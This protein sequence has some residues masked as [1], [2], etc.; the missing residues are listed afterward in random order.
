MFTSTKLIALF[1]LLGSAI[2]IPAAAPETHSISKRAINPV[3]LHVG[4][5]MKVES[6][7]KSNTV[8]G[9]GGL[10]VGYWTFAFDGAEYKKENFVYTLY[11]NES[12]WN[13]SITPPPQPINKAFNVSSPLLSDPCP[14]RKSDS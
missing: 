13:S 14:T 3:D 1:A 7:A 5:Y 6:P 4:P 12:Y 2:A 8:G 10:G 9:W 11:K